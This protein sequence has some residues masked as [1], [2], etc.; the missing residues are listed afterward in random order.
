ML[1]SSVTNNISCSTAYRGLRICSETV[2]RTRRKE[3][4]K[5]LFISRQYNVKVADLA[6]ARAK[7]ITTQHSPRS[8][9]LCR[10]M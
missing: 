2:T 3:E 9:E 5:D 7:L 4:L 8:V 10:G 1:P 6:I